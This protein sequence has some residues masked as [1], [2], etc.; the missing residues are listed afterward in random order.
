[1]AVFSLASI[2]SLSGLTFLAGS[3]LTVGMAAL[4][5]K[6]TQALDN[7]RSLA[8][9]G[10]P[11]ALLLFVVLLMAIIPS[12]MGAFSL[13]EKSQT[14]ISIDFKSVASAGWGSSTPK[15]VNFKNDEIIDI[16]TVV[17][18]AAVPENQVRFVCGRESTEMC[19]GLDAPLQV[20]ETPGTGSITVNTNTKAYVVVCGDEANGKYCISVA[21]QGG[22]ARD[23]CS[24][25]CIQ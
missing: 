23:T 4:A 7:T 13:G 14:M 19:S 12:Y 22:D 6:F 2:Q 9:T 21:R 1:M 10:I 17:G 20:D 11:A 16:K 18:D 5:V 8:S 24:E 25:T 15:Q 3:A